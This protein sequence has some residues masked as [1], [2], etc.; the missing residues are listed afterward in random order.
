MI[1]SKWWKKRPPK[2]QPQ[3]RKPTGIAIVTYDALKQRNYW[4][5]TNG[6]G[7]DTMS[8]T[9]GQS[10]PLNPKALPL[11]TRLEIYMP[12]PKDGK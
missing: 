8:M 12:E 9:G 10:L 2:P 5:T 6:D 3:K 4:D 11:G 7:E 1:F